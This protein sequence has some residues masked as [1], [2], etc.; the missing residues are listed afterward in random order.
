MIF[1]KYLKK[2]KGSPFFKS[3]TSAEE[4]EE[5]LCQYLGLDMEEKP[6]KKEEKEV[7]SP[8]DEEI[9]K[10]IENTPVEDLLDLVYDKKVIS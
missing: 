10:F 4:G 6:K 3:T 2:F 1:K 5:K 9:N 7:K 8:T